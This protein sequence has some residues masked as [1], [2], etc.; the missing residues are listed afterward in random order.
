M[1]NTAGTERV[2][3]IT[4]GFDSVN[5]YLGPGTTPRTDATKNCQIRLEMRYPL[6]WNFFL[7]S[8]L[9]HGYLT[10]PGDVRATFHTTFELVSRDTQ[11]VGV[12]DLVVNGTDSSS[13][14]VITREVPVAVENELGSM[15]AASSASIPGGGGAEGGNTDTIV[16]LDRWALTALRRDVLVEGWMEEGTSLVQQVKLRWRECPST[17]R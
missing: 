17:D 15:C 10:L 2:Q 13:G 9:W 12:S 8:S 3:T 7:T 11:A 4:L 14:Q 1:V 16:V 6:G 5:L